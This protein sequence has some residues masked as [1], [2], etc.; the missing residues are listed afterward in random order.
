MPMRGNLPACRPGGMSPATRMSRYRR[1]TAGTHH[2]RASSSAIS[3]SL[4]SIV[5]RHHV[6]ANVGEASWMC[7]PARRAHTRVHVRDR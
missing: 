3:D 1:L 5:K 6:G 7:W 2:R 4:G